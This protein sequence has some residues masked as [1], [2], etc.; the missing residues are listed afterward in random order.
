[1]DNVPGQS[2][3]SSEGS[4]QLPTGNANRPYVTLNHYN[5]TFRIRGREACRGRNNQRKLHQ[6][7]KEQLPLI[8]SC[9]LDFNKFYVM[10]PREDINL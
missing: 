4:V 10:K 5:P 1:M 7:Y 6:A 2:H 3:S 9:T 8:E